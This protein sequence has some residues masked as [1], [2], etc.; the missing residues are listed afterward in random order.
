MTARYIIPTYLHML[1]NTFNKKL[2]FLL[3]VLTR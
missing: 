1:F 3:K 2:F